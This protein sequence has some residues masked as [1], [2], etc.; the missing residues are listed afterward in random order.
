MML[1]NPNHHIRFCDITTITAVIVMM[2]SN[3]D[4][5][6]NLSLATQSICQST[7]VQNCAVINKHI[8]ADH[9]GRAQNLYHNQAM[10]VQLYGAHELSV[11]VA[12][13]KD[14]ERLC[15][16]DERK[17]SAA[18]GYLVAMDIDVMAVNIQGD[19]LMI[20]ER[21][22]LKTHERICLNITE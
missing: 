6:H 8:S 19:W 15:G 12:L 4:A 9:T 13:F 18:Y 7:L 11:L 5:K 2:G 10:K 1:I 3:D 14:V 16:R 20:Q 21:L 17:N 22:P